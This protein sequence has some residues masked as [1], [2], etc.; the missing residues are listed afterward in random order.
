MCLD[1]VR[2][3]DIDPTFVISNHIKINHLPEF[4]QQLGDEE[5]ETLKCFIKI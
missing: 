5:N 3:A 4:Y 1:K 2:S